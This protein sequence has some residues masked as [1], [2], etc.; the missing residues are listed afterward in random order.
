MGSEERTFVIGD[1]WNRLI[2]P[3]TALQEQ[4]VRLRARIVASLSIPVFLFGAGSMLFVDAPAIPFFIAVCVLSAAAYAASRTTHIWVAAALIV[5][6][7]V[8]TPYVGIFTPAADT[9]NSAEVTWMVLTVLAAGLCL[10]LLH[11]GIFAVL[12]IVIVLCLCLFNPGIPVEE[13][14]ETTAL[15]LFV[16]VVTLIYV[17]VRTAGER[18]IAKAAAAKTHRRKA[19]ELEGL[20]AELLEAQEQLVQAAKLAAVGELS[21]G[22]AHELNNPLTAIMAYTS[23]LKHHI[24]KGGTD[25]ELLREH[26]DEMMGAAERCRDITAG[27]LKF[28]RGGS[29]E[30]EAV[31]LMEVARSAVAL[32]QPQLKRLRSKAVVNLEGS[33]KVMGNANRL[34][35]VVVN[36][37]VNAGQANEGGGEIAIDGS[38]V[39]EEAVFTVTDNG[40]GM[41]EETQTR[42][43]DPFFT[44]KAPGSGTGLGLSVS[45][46]IIQEHGGRIDV[47]STLGEGTTFTIALPLKG[48]EAVNRPDGTV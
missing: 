9:S 31:D 21:A 24:D 34:E 10:P 25:R 2:E 29:K 19:I 46:G 48:H 4:T 15:V 36:L 38:I 41:D 14:A 17:N 33:L 8:T 3:S 6:A 26:L 18:L 35:Q 43:F 45:S 40:C 22:V 32:A 39:G 30:L 11:F 37:L 12:N 5:A 27:L 47:D 13:S 42:I 1:L 44:T 20:N 16:S 23:V 7:C 28:S